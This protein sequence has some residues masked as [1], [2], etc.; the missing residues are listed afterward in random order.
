MSVNRKIIA[1][2][3]LC[4][5]SNLPTVIS[6]CVAGYLI[7]KDSLSWG[8]ALI[9]IGASLLY[10]GGMA[11]N[12]VID[13]RYDKK[14]KTDRP[15]ARAAISHR[16]GL[17]LTLVFLFVGTLILLFSGSSLPFVGALLLSITI[18]N[19]IHKKTSSAIFIMGLCR[20]L[21]YLIAGYSL[22]YNNSLIPWAIVLGLYTA[23]I[24]L[25]AR[26][27]DSENESGLYGLILISLPSF[28]S[29]YFIIVKSYISIPIAISSLL[30]L[31]WIAYC[32][33]VIKSEVKGKI[34]KSVSLMIAGMCLI[35]SMAVCHA[36]G[37][38]GLYFVI[39]L[40]FIVLFQRKISGT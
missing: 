29:L 27:E 26:G 19:F 18:Y 9:V 40:P 15:I 35:D 22:G 6:N 11:M 4:R 28:L 20:S 8:L 2:L 25:V 39:F 12:D 14:H 21:L 17:V 37:F 13:L 7:S 23:G 16:F 30:F 31:F 32:F 5:I 10:S 38:H 33:R 34:G 36:I 3:E 1:I 24:T